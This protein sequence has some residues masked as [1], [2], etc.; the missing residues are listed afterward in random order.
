MLIAIVRRT[1]RDQ[2]RSLVGWT[3]G[4]A[5]LLLVEAALWP[6]VRD[7]AGLDE[8]LAGYPEGMKE[9]FNLDS[10]GTGI[11]FLNA[12]LFTLV[13]PALFIGFGVARGARLVAG[14]EESGMIEV[15]LVTPLSTTM[16]YLGRAVGLFL[17]V[18]FLGGVVLGMT[19]LISVGFSMGVTPV[20]AAIGSLSL[21]LLGLEYGFVALAVGAMTAV[22]RWL[23]Q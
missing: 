20:D 6:S 17:S 19:L 21:S 9:L 11:G 10:M 22:E 15:L 2:R 1:L 4:L 12:E 14:E 8:L 23:L 5:A 7:M 16:L 3:L 18:F 13:L